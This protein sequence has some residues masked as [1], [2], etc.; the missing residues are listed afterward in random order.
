M[1]TFTI[2][3]PENVRRAHGSE[4]T[5]AEWE[6]SP[7]LGRGDTLGLLSGA[8]A[9]LADIVLTNRRE[10]PI[11]FWTACSPRAWEGLEAHLQVC[12]RFRNNIG[13]AWARSDRCFA[14][15]NSVR[16]RRKTGRESGRSARLEPAPQAA[17]LTQTDAG[18]FDSA[19]RRP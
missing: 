11:N 5:H 1:A 17:G 14:W 13:P 8:R 3:V 12:C 10:R 7:D 6:V 18:N 4:E 9:V 15:A 16:C 2:P 19:G